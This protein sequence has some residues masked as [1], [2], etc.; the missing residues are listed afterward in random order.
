MEIVVASGDRASITLGVSSTAG[1]TVDSGG[2][3]APLEFQQVLHRVRQMLREKK[4]G[5]YSA[6]DLL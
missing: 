2:S 4:G 6:E 1:V 5:T 3:S